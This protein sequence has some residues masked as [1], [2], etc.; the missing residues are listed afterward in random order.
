MSYQLFLKNF[1]A[2]FSIGIHEF[3]KNARQRLFINVELEVNSLG[4]KDE[5]YNVLDYDFL[6]DAL[7]NIAKGEHINLQETLCERIIA[8]CFSKPQ[9]KKIIVETG[10]P[11]VYPD[12]EI[13]GCRMTRER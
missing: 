13:V 4:D 6:I 1:R 12:C 9:V 2:D 10:K 5:I 7:R 3:E 11:D 8:I